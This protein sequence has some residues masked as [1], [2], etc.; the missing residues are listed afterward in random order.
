M[1]SQFT[2]DSAFEK[3]GELILGLRMKGSKEFGIGIYS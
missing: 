2:R 3:Q 1:P